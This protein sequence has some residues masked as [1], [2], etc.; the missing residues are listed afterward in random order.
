MTVMALT[1]KIERTA[2]GFFHPER[3][4]ITQ[5][6]VAR[7]ELPWVKKS[8]RPTL[9]ELNPLPRIS[10]LSSL[11]PFQGWFARKSTQGRRCCANPGLNDRNPVG[12][13][14]ANDAD[15]SGVYLGV[16]E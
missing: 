10:L 12:V 6:R 4:K 2:L 8:K 14:L 9:K 11:Q 1:I 16:G 7:N 15:V 3:M 13:A 5:P